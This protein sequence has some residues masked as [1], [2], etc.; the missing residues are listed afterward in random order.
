[1]RIERPLRFHAASRASR[2][3][4]AVLAFLHAPAHV[5][6]ST[7]HGLVAGSITNVHAETS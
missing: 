6:P 7:M 4:P 5:Q 1:M 2:N 3:V